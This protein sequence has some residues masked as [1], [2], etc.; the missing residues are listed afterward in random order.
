MLDYA[1]RRYRLC[2][3]IFA[4]E[5]RTVRGRGAGIASPDSTSALLRLLRRSNLGACYQPRG[6]A[7]YSP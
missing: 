7:R 6:T 1:A 4:R 2:P 5:R 3:A